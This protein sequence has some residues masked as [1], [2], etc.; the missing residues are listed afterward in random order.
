MEEYETTDKA[1]MESAALGIVAGGL[2]AVIV[3]T[4]GL[5]RLIILGIIGYVV[6]KLW[7]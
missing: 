3:N 2:V 5:K 7:K 1:I 4:I 6:Y